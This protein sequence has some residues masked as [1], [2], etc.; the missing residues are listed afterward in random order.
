MAPDISNNPNRI[1]SRPYLRTNLI[2]DACDKTP[3]SRAFSPM[4]EAALRGGSLT[5]SLPVRGFHPNLNW[6]VTTNDALPSLIETERAWSP[7]FAT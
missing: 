2:G 1:E 6:R 4:S 7:V 5:P 3:L